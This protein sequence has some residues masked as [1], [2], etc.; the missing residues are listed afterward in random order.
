[1]FVAAGVEL[2]LTMVPATVPTAK[3]VSCRALRLARRHRQI[4]TEGLIWMHGAVGKDIESDICGK[5]SDC[6]SDRAGW[7]GS[8]S[9]IGGGDGIGPEPVTL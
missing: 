4:Q 2:L 9:E 1:M 5:L 7:K 3:D 6:E 8:A